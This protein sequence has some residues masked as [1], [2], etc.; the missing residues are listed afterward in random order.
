MD[1]NNINKELQIHHI[2][3]NDV[4]PAEYNPRTL[5]QKKFE[6]IKDSLS[7]FG[8]VDPVVVNKHED[9][10]NILVGGH[11][12]VKVA[13]DMGYEKIPAVFVNLT[14]EEEK[15]LNVRLNKNQGDWDFSTLKDSF[16]SEN[17]I[18][19][20]FAEQELDSQF[21]EIAKLEEE[22]I[23]NTEEVTE[24]KYPIIPKYNE[25]YTTFLIFCNNELDVHWM[26]NFLQLT[27]PHRD[28]KSKAISP[29]HCITAEK[30]QEIIMNQ[31]NKENE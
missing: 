26:K 25:K 22:T 16:T 27:E 9:R 2:D 12:R 30:F 8:F 15:E 6:D 4:T 11:Q 5:S 17:L 14:L 3:I 18:D 1:N 28:Y 13:K 31:S 20:G 23:E 19:W 29:S 24:K 7:K 21:K 10:E